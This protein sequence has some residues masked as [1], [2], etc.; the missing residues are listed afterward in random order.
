MGEDVERR[1]HGPGLHFHHLRHHFASVLIDGGESVKVVQERLGH[2]SPDET[3]QTYTHLWPTS[4]Q[5]TRSVVESAWAA[6]T[7]PGRTKWHSSPLTCGK[8]RVG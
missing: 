3:P 7:D 2:A 4:D 8:R 5:R 1:R 6:V